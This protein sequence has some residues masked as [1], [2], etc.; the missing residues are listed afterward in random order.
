MESAQNAFL[1]FKDRNREVPG[2]SSSRRFPH[3]ALPQAVS[4]R[5]R[6]PPRNDIKGLTLHCACVPIVACV[7]DIVWTIMRFSVRKQTVGEFRTPASPRKGALW[8]F[9]NSPIVTT[10]QEKRPLFFGGAVPQLV[11]TR[12]GLRFRCALSTVCS[13][14]Q[15]HS[16]AHFIPRLP[17]RDVVGNP[18]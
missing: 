5:L 16:N 8:V 4:P 17:H 15:E 11:F 13:R 12:R 3:R 2:D 9:L 14:N 18:G 7:D 1:I 6:R 10:P